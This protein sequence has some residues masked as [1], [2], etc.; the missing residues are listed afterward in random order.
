MAP[1]ALL[2]NRLAEQIG[3]FLQAHMVVKSACKPFSSGWSRQTWLLD[4][5]RFALV[6]LDV[7]SDVMRQGKPSQFW[8]M[9]FM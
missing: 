2:H 8:Q 7:V 9:R 5:R 1:Q 4:R 3:A 6:Q